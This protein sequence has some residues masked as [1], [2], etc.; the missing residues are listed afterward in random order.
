MGRTTNDRLAAVFMGFGALL[1]LLWLRCAWLQVLGNGRLSR[2]GQAQHWMSRPLVAERGTILDH[3]GRVLAMST[4]V[5]S[6]FANARKIPA[7]NLLAARMGKILG[8][9]PKSLSKRLA[10]DK[11]FVWLARHID[12]ELEDAMDQF[13][14][15][16]VGLLE[17]P[18]RVYPQGRL[19]AHLLG[20]VDVDQHGLEGVELAYN[21]M[22]H[23]RTGWLSTM[24][25]ARGEML[26]GPWTVSAQP[27]VGYNVVL[28]IDSVVQAAAEDALAWGIEEFHAK[29]GSLVVMEPSTGAILAIANQ[30]DFDANRP[31]NRPI[32]SRR[33]RA[34][35]DVAEPGS[36][37]KVVT[38]S[39]L[40]QEGL[41]KPEERFYCEEGSWH[42]IGHHILH[43]HKPH[44]W[45]TFREVIQN[46]SNIGTSKA[47][48]RLPPETLYRYIRGFGF[49]QRTGI[50]LRGEVNGIIQPPAKWSKLSPFIIPIGQEV[51]TT[52]VQLAGMMSIVANGGWKVHPHVVERIEDEDGRVVRSRADRGGTIH[53]AEAP[54]RA[55]RR[56]AWSPRKSPERGSAEGEV[57][58]TAKFAT[59]AER[60]RFLRADVVEQLE[61][62]L[63]GVVESGTGQLAKVPGLTIAG[64]TGTAQKLEPN[65]RYSHSR[66]VASFVGF[67]PVPDPRF[68]MVVCIDEPHPLYFG[69][70]V[71]APVFKRVVEQLASYWDLKPAGPAPLIAK[72]QAGGDD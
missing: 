44:G 26:L 11:G 18:K 15:D 45:L 13:R 20:F 63:T 56:Q 5:P 12:P 24:R 9:D 21:G 6:V 2:L 62:M 41:V 3:G 46:S 38:A 35:T 32:E 51:A 54:R 57:S 36:V 39:A 68:V 25:D 33:L 48:Q 16:G 27:Q 64:K 23:G 28:T 30:P 43:D 55:P 71:A 42:T 65:G 40:L 1:A 19:A 14:R 17:E 59:D 49:G 47:A 70:V 10:K 66:F 34:I 67:G 69:G 60:E 58:Q 61:P 29:G 22:L 53:A 7:K 8:R 4:R 52:P 50:E 31:G 72:A 37:F